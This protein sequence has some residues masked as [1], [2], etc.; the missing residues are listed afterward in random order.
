MSIG[1]EIDGRRI[2]G[3]AWWKKDSINHVSRMYVK[4]DSTI[5]V[6]SLAFATLVSDL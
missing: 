6:A 1:I 4:E 5:K 3:K 2:R